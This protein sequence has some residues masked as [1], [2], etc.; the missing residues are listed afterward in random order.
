MLKKNIRALPI[1]IM[2]LG[3]VLAFDFTAFGQKRKGNSKKGELNARKE[4]YNQIES[5]D[6]FTEGVKY[7]IL[8]DM[9]KALMLFQKSLEYDPDNDAAYY[10]IA[11]ILSEK[12][13][14]GEALGYSSKALSLSPQNKY[15]YLLNAE[16]LTRQSNFNAAAE[17]Y[18][19]MLR[20]VE[21]TDEYLFDLAALYLHQ[22]E[23][24]KALDTYER[25]EKVFGMVPELVYQKQ[26]IYLKLNKL[27]RAVEEGIRLINHLPGEQQY[28]INLGEILVA[29]GKD[30]EAIPYFEDLLAISP[31]ASEARLFLAKIYENTN[32]QAK[33]IENY[34]LAF[35]DENLSLSLKKDL[36]AKYITDLRSANGR[37]DKDKAALVNELTNTLVE[38]HPSE[39]NSYVLRGDYLISVDSTRAA[40]SAYLHALGINAD[41]FAV[42]QNVL[43]LDQQ[44]SEPDSA[45]KH[46]E[47]ALE[48]YP[49]QAILYFF[50]GNSHIMNKSFEDAAYMLEQGKRLASSDPVLLTYFNS[51]LGYAYN[52]LEEYEKSDE[53]FEAALEANPNDEQT[54]NNYSYFLALRQ[55]RLGEALKMSS[56]LVKNNPDNATY[57]DTHAWV[58]YMSGDYQQA[59]D[60]LERALNA[61]EGTQSGEVIEHYGDVLFKLGKVDE[62]VKQ[63]KRAKGMND[64]SEL[65][66]K[67]IADRKLYE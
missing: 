57:L 62:A 1:I 22:N 25:A 24:Q 16:I 14:Y 48:L 64:A 3:C 30:K 27:D 38:T 67:K 13:E 42:W 34:R 28:V 43:N 53:A 39:A 49:N 66:D 4:E 59:K 10:Q 18:E 11:K 63:W 40:R 51:Q 15:Y 29:N 46:S 50:N 21:D 58:L 65:I 52:E 56:K 17:Q 33:A 60:F 36:V 32:Q 8:E 12:G 54:L 5:T 20:E 61:K 19:T 23:Y 7:Y 41:N 47:E 2:I 9:A 45:L 31:Q 44:L 55:D 35:A 26:K 6:K 37:V